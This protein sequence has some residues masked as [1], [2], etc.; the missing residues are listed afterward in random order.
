VEVVLPS[1][2]A[3]EELVTQGYNIGS[4][5][6]SVATVYATQG[7]LSRLDAAGFKYREIERQP[8]RPK[9]LGLYHNYSSLSSELAALAGAHP[10]IC[11][12]YTL[13]KSVQDRELWA[14]LIT[15]NPN[16]EEDEPEFKYVSTMHGDEPLGTEMCL[17]L[18][19]MLL[20]EYG[21]E[22]E[23]T[24]LIDTTA[25]WIIPLMN[26]DG[27]ELG[28]RYNANGFDLNRSFPAYP[29]DFTD[30]IF[31]GGALGDAGLP[32][33]VRNITR[34]TAMNSFVLSA[35][36][37]TGALLV[38]Y[39][40]DDDGMGSV[41]SP[42]PDD[43][44]FEDIS[45]RY[46]VHNIPMWNSPYYVDG[47]TNGAAWYSI[48]GGMQDWN[49][50]YVGCNEVTIELSN[51]GIP[52][53][54]QIP[55]FWADNSQSM[56]SFLE[57][58]HIGV[59]GI[60]TDGAT[61]EPLW[62]QVTVAGNSQ[63][64]FTDPNV[65]DYHRMLLP[66]TYDLT[67]S[68]QDY[69]S[70]SVED[71]VVTDGAAIRVDIELTKT[72][73]K[74]TP[75]TDLEAEGPEGGPFSPDSI[76]YTIENLNETGIG[77]TVTADQSWIL[78]NNT[79][80]YLEGYD[81]TE[82]TISIGEDAN[83]LGTG[84]YNGTINFVNTTDHDGDT[85]R[86]VKL[87][88]GMP[89]VQYSWN[90]DEDPGW[91]TTGQWAWGQPAGFGGQYG[92]PDPKRGYTGIN[93]LGYNLQGDYKNSMPEYYLT[94]RP[95]NCSNS[96]D[97]ATIQVSND[98]TNWTEIWA[99]SSSSIVDPSWILQSF[100]ISDIA[101]NQSSVFIRWTMG[102]TDSS[103]RYCGW[104]IDDVEII[105]IGG[106]SSIDL[107]TPDDSAV[108]P[109]SPPATFQWQTDVPCK[110]KIEFAPTSAFDTSTITFPP[111]AWMPD[112]STDTIPAQ[113]WQK[114]WNMVRKMEDN[115]GIVY[116]RVT[117]MSGPS[118]PI[119]TSETR[120]FTIAD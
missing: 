112:T 69:V 7:E 24:D 43:L 93:I 4:V 103:W 114:T 46:S 71:V 78:I 41:D 17:Y 25:I 75:N 31:D 111:E 99:N 35:N 108:L 14:M 81:M 89:T 59:R 77:Y 5:R 34:W 15:D 32:V 63:P 68:A 66:G 106:S 119:D 48:T 117:G 62:A 23:I 85:T 80:G 72:G 104:N 18:I 10:E 3:L 97:H 56:L 11:R 61:G 16:D 44:L 28:Q 84:E 19:T 115:S 109:D 21:T 94:T 98:K 30:N 96:Y 65:G 95:I 47:I 118:A 110:F 58:V 51:I 52:P 120:S 88:V 22:T 1:H 116:W 45:R 82:V 6:G 42:T 8:F 92:N 13:G 105:G 74:V 87:M 54:N 76:V 33:E 90:M 64:V 102:P 26:P 79:S 91:K 86:G 37:H 67:F 70:Q 73:I 40:Y 9:H 57:A 83:A 100:D 2:D 55:N 50:R 49:Y 36:F 39:P 107:I 101:D 20:N 53:A 27:L 60:V 29:Y 12:L 113:K 38:N